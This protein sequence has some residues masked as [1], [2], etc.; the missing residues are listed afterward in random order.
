MIRG[1]PVKHEACV[2]VFCLRSAFRTSAGNPTR[3][4][5]LLLRLLLRRIYW[6]LAP[7]YNGA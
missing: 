7:F 4:I 5:L 1:I 2:V 3:L 6:L